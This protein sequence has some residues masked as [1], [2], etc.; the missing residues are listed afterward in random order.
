MASHTMSQAFVSNFLGQSPNW[1]KLTI[2]GFL[3]LNPI[4]VATAGPFVTGWCLIAEFIFCLAMALKCYPL[5][6]GGL[7]AIEA[8]ALGLTSAEAVYQ[9][10][11]FNFPVIMLLMFMVAGIYFLKELL[12]FTFTKILL[13]VESKVLLSLLFSAMA[14]VLSAFLDAL[15]VTAVVITVAHGFYLVYHKIASG[16]QYH[17]D[18]DASGDDQVQ[19]LHRSDLDQFRAFLRS[20]MMHAAVGT[21]LGGVCT[22]VGEPQNL[23]I[24]KV[25]QWEFVEFFVRV[26]PVSM[27]VLAAGLLTCAVLEMT[28]WFGFGA[29]LSPA[30]RSILADYDR[31]ESAKRTHQD[32]ARLWIQ[33]IAAI[34]LVIALGLHLAEVGV[35][36]LTVIVFA[37]AFNG[38]IEER[39]LGH[40]F[41][42]ALPFTSLLVVFFGIVAS[43]TNSIC[44]HP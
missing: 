19:E 43:S 31:H 27:P 37:T 14:A 26:A 6:P 1:Y 42:E 30:V 24:A 29:R 33:G 22:L 11:V 16:K 36:G 12:L 21:A 13:K 5:Q 41:E 35:I 3:I 23:L 8:V 25:A 18:H 34:F 44:S 10:T 7:L 15:T 20:L 28:G 4:L 32:V 40:A 17:H 9:E 39:R 2:I 38:I